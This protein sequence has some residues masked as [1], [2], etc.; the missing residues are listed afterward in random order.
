MSHWPVMLKVQGRRCVIVGGGRVALRRAAS[1]LECQARVTV[2]APQ[3]APEL[4][5]LAVTCVER[6]Y[7]AGDLANALLVVVATNDPAVNAQ[8]AA[9]AAAAGVL[10]NRSD[11]PEA[12][13][14]SIPAHAHHG[15]ITLAVTTGGISAT[16]AAQIRRELSQ[17]L[18]PAWEQLLAI[19]APYRDLIQQ[20]MPAG[21]QRVARLS[22]LCDSEAMALLKVHG[23]EAFGRY[24]EQ[25]A[26]Q[27][28]EDARLARGED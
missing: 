22:K 28:F 11:D 10:V 8:V 12:G 24:C 9:D 27:N 3:I 7:Q 23:S 13:D 17:A 16:A 25:L 21:S 19:A 2:I 14:L 4:R 6:A 5:S 26:S 15:P 1:L 18:D 20:R